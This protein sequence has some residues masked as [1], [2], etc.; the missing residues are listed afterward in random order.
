MNDMRCPERDRTIMGA[1]QY[2]EVAIEEA[3]STA[4]LLADA[5]SGIKL[6]GT[7]VASLVPLH[8]GPFGTLTAGCRRG[9][10]TMR[11]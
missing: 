2:P 6:D 8:D 4:D 7:A 1:D 11:I 10:V 3:S 9:P 5:M